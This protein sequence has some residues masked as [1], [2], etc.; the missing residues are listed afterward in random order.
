M[1][2]ALTR[3]ALVPSSLGLLRLNFIMR[4]ANCWAK[5]IALCFLAVLLLVGCNQD[6]QK[7][8]NAA[9]DLA[10]DWKMNPA[11]P[12]VGVSDC[13]LTLRDKQG[14]PVKGAK[15]KLEGNMSHPG[16]QPSMAEMKEA[17]PGTYVA[18]LDFTMGGDW[19]VL[20]DATLPD[21]RLWHHQVDVPNVRSGK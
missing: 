5:A 2:N 19:F 7:S 18:K 21:G 6:N 17:A 20:I 12:K 3:L 10:F 4:Y 16:M 11:P 13:T 9:S 8:N 1:A 15:V 14:Q